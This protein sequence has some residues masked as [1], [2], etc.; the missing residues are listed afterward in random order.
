MNANDDY[1]GD[2][3]HDEE[4]LVS[5]PCSTKSLSHVKMEQTSNKLR[6]RKESQ[7]IPMQGSCA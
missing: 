5:A 4:F 7:Q 2:G 1:G 3:T 6:S